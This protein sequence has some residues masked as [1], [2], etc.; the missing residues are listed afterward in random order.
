MIMYGTRSVE[1]RGNSPLQG[2]LRSQEV[3]ASS[4]CKIHGAFGLMRFNE[5]DPHLAVIR[6]STRGKSHTLQRF[7]K[8]D[9]TDESH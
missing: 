3:S 9:H 4:S 1:D 7:C 5:T 8:C 6:N 2:V